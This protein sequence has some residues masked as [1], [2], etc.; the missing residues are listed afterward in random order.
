MDMQQKELV[1][2]VVV[3]VVEGVPW[4]SRKHNDFGEEKG[5]LN[6]GKASHRASY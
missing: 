3:V 6:G 1:V 5:S 2:V 4:R